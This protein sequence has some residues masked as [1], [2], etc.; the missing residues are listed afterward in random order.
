MG[1]QD[2]KL[3][4]QGYKVDGRW[5]QAKSLWLAGNIRNPESGSKVIW[6]MNAHLNP[7]P[8]K[9]SGDGLIIQ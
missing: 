5:Y 1:H 6:V 9:E 8:F 4:Q 2:Y 3:G 7:N